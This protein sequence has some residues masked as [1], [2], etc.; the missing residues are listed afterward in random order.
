MT[1]YQARFTNQVRFGLGL[2]WGPSFEH[3]GRK[4]IGLSGEFLFWY[5]SVGVTYL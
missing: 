1:T 5:L 2:W 3:K 4:V